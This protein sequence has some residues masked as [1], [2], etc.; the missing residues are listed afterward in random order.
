MEEEINEYGQIALRA[1]E[2]F[3]KEQ[4]GLDKCWMQAAYKIYPQSISCAEKGCPRYA[5]LGLCEEGMVI[6]I[7]KGNYTGSILNK[8]YAVAAVKLLRQKN[9]NDI[10]P[11][12][13]WNQLPLNHPDT[14]NHQMDV[15]S[16][17]WRNNLISK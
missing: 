3:K 11:K 2:I 5:F 16:A 17:L 8:A 7:E 9:L 13:L 14:H 6:G 12:E 1:V 10:N 4:Y 15:V